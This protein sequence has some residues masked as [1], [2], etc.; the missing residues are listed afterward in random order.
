[1]AILA[2]VQ[3]T[4]VTTSRTLYNLRGGHADRRDVLHNLSLVSRNK[5]WNVCILEDLTSIQKCCGSLKVAGR[6][7]QSRKYY[8]KRQNEGLHLKGFLL[9]CHE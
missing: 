2:D 4:V 8:I 9:V 3:D 1:M 7:A 6:V 5:S